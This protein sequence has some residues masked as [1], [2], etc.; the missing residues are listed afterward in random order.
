[1]GDSPQGDVEG[2]G[3]AHLEAVKVHLELGRD[4]VSCGPGCRPPTPGQASSTSHSW[5][6]E[7]GVGEEGR[8]GRGPGWAVERAGRRELARGQLC[9][10]AQAWGWTGRS[11]SDT[12]LTCCPACRWE[13]L[14]TCT[15]WHCVSW[16]S[17]LVEQTSRPCRLSVERGAAGCQTMLSPVKAVSRV[18]LPHPS[19]PSGCH[20]KKRS[21]EHPRHDPG[22]TP[23]QSPWSVREALTRRSREQPSGGEHFMAVE[24]TRAPRT[25]LGMDA[26]GCWQKLLKIFPVGG[27]GG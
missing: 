3:H 12:G 17:R 10:R 20:G 23:S 6:P 14:G 19:L 13:A 15:V 18:S 24:S 9:C 22:V 1:M 25:D 7:S 4:G 21:P 5:N 8:L 26:G 16:V 2:L 11:R 27:E